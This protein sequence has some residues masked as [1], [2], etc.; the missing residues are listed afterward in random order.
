MAGVI[1]RFRWSAVIGVFLLAAPV[2]AGEC[3][4]TTRVDRMILGNTADVAGVGDYRFGMLAA[5]GTEGTDHD[6][7]QFD[8]TYGFESRLQLQAQFDR[9]RFIDGGIDNAVTAGVGYQVACGAESPVL[10]LDLGFHH[11]G[12]NGPDVG[13]VTGQGTPFV[14]WQFGVHHSS[15]ISS[16]RYN[17]ALIFAENFLPLVLE[18]AASDTDQ[19]W[20]R[21]FSWAVYPFMGDSVEVGLA[22]VDGGGLSEGERHL[23]VR[24]TATF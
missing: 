24:L 13:F 7:V 6:F 17:G 20:D 4:E 15:A 16:T 18:A 11:D 2:Y 9:K 12:G 5:Q 19:G 3:P 23:V 22:Y 21:T 10:R 1:A 14:G 8:A